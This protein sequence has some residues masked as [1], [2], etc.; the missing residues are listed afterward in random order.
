MQNKTHQNLLI[1][2][3]GVDYPK[4]STKNLHTKYYQ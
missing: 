4:K 2:K 3:N 1:K